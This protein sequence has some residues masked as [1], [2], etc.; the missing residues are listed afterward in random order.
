MLD[1]AFAAQKSIIHRLDPRPKIIV[2]MAFS[3]VMAAATHWRAMAC[4]AAFSVLVLSLARLPAVKVLR[5]LLVV[6]GL[7]LVLWLLLP[8]SVEGTPIAKV[9]PFIVTREGVRYAALLTARCNIIVLA[10][11]SLVSTVPIFTLGRAMATLWIPDKVVQLFFFTYRY[12][13]VIHEEYV[14]ILRALKIRGFE[15]GTNL[16]TYRTY[17]YLMGML[18]LK[19]YERSGRIRQAMVCRGFQ[20]RFYNLNDLTMRPFDWLLAISMGLAVAVIA[21]VQWTGIP[22]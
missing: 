16:H 2:A 8:V 17:A 10:L 4:G 1:D 11:L 7:I 6:N 20:G 5:R 14:R 3:V 19:S 15:P 9:G 21:G 18:F 12:V 13:H 22:L